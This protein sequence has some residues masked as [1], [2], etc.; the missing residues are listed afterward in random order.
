MDSLKA[1][2]VSINYYELYDDKWKNEI[3][4]KL[5]LHYLVK[6]IQVFKQRMNFEYQMYLS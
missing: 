3:D 4:Q 2:N 6:Q 5:H 1:V